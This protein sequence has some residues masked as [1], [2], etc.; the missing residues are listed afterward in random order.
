MGKIPP[1]CKK[2]SKAKARARLVEQL[3]SSRPPVMFFS[4]RLP[5]RPITHRVTTVTDTPTAQR[6]AGPIRRTL[7][8]LGWMYYHYGIAI[9]VHGMHPIEIVTING[10]VIVFFVVVCWVVI[11]YVPTQIHRL[12]TSFWRR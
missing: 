2:K 3:L 6:P 5:P 4:S 7:N 8:R 12:V 11:I 9:P 10:T 1:K